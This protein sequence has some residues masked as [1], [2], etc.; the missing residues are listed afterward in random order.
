MSQTQVVTNPAI[1][2]ERGVAGRVA[3]AER[4]T[5]AEPATAERE[6]RAGRGPAETGIVYRLRR[7]DATDAV[8][9]AAMLTDLS[10]QSAYRRFMGGRRVPLPRVLTQLVQ[11]A[12]DRGAWL[13]LAGDVVVAHGC[14]AFEP[15]STGYPAD[16]LPV[17]ELGVVV[18]DDWQDR[19]LGTRLLSLVTGDAIRAGAGSVRLNILAENRRLVARVARDWPGTIPQRDGVLLT[20]T[21]PVV[22]FIAGGTSTG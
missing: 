17:A 12:D 20:Y 21:I 11:A 3:T 22:G 13:G 4:E 9:L 1:E 5:H 10:P 15:H 7:A 16:E 6:H 8:G 2:P 14:W 19:G 18:A